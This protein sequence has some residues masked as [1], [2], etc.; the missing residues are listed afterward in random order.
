MTAPARFSLFSGFAL[1]VLAVVLALFF[2]GCSQ[3]DGAAKEA[4]AD[5]LAVL[6]PPATPVE[7]VT[8]DAE[9]FE[10]TIELTGT[11]EAPDD[12]TLSAES[13]GRLT[14]VA[15]EGTY[16]RPG[17]TVARID[18]ALPRTALSQAEAS[19]DVALAQLELAQDQFDRQEP[20]FA[21]SIISALEF[22]GVRTQLA[23]AKAQV[24]QSEAA[25]EQAQE[26]LSNT[27]VT[28][29]FGGTVEQHFADRGEMV[30]PGMQVA[31]VVA[32]QRV[33]IVAG[34]PE[35]Y[36]NDIRR[37]T[38]VRIAPTAYGLEDLRGSVSFVGSAIN[39]QNRTFPVEVELDNRNGTL[40]PAMVT[41]LFVT[42]SVLDNV[43]AVPLAAI[44]RD[45]VGASVYVA[46][47]EAE[48][49][50]GERLYTAERRRVALG[51][52]ASGRVVVND[53]LQP[54]DRV[55]VSGQTQIATGDRVRVVGQDEQSVAALRR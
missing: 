48:A 45:E 43:L 4:A 29:P 1:L 26:A 22:Q 27:V 13:S 42:R 39:P 6:A 36:A 14:F 24:A 52:Q 54:G 12:A 30:A 47:P 18:P 50:G 46:V 17:G 34:V 49:K 3:P 28:A 10:D 31:R 37:G 44:V 7:V 16:V 8:I 55:I 2:S 9:R 40:K 25:V 35:R 19:R 33:E 38:P 11:V 41:K 20:L 15:E 51:P 23:Q 21:D 32:T 53:G 5:S